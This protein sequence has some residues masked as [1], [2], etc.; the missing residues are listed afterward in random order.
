MVGGSNAL[1]VGSS[2]HVIRLLG[3]PE[4]LPALSVRVHGGVLIWEQ[5]PIT[6]RLEGEISRRQALAIA[7]RI[8]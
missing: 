2:D 5:G 3:A 7:G 8:R 6:L 1:W 4:A